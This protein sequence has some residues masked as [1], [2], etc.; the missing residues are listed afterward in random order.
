LAGKDLGIL[1]GSQYTKVGEEIVQSPFLKD[2]EF[3][4]DFGY[5]YTRPVYKNIF[6][7]VAIIDLA[8]PTSLEE[9]LKFKKDISLFKAVSVSR[10][11]YDLSDLK[12][13]LGVFSTDVVVSTGFGAAVGSVVP[14]VGTIVGGATGLLTGA[15][16]GTSDVLA[17]RIAL[18]QTGSEE[19]SSGVGV[20]AGVSAELLTAGPV[21]KV[22]SKTFAANLSIVG[23]P[24]SIVYEL[25]DDKLRVVKYSEFK[26]GTGF[27]TKK[28]DVVDDFVVSRVDLVKDLGLKKTDDLFRLAGKQ[29]KQ[30]TSDFTKGRYV[31]SDVY[32]GSK[33]IIGFGD[34]FLSTYAKKTTKF[35]KVLDQIDVAKFEGVQRIKMRTGKDFLEKI[36]ETIKPSVYDDSLESISGFGKVKQMEQKLLI[37]KGVKTFQFEGY[38]ISKTQADELAEA[39][40]KT[41]AP[42]SKTKK[43]SQ[44]KQL[45]SSKTKPITDIVEYKPLETFELPKGKSI[46]GKDVDDYSTFLSQTR[47]KGLS[48]SMVKQG[49]EIIESPVIK[50]KTETLGFEGVKGKGKIV[51]TKIKGLPD[52]YSLQIAARLDELPKTDPF[53][54]IIRKTS[55]QEDVLGLGVTKIKAGPERKLL[56]ESLEQAKKPLLVKEF[57]SNVAEYLATGKE[58]ALKRITELSKQFDLMQ[59]TSTS[60]AAR[61]SASAK[62]NIAQQK[63]FEEFSKKGIKV[64]ETKLTSFKSDLQKLGKESQAKFLEFQ[65]KGPK[66]DVESQDKLSAFEKK[67]GG[68]GVTTTKETS[69]TLDDKKINDFLNKIEKPV[70]EKTKLK[71]L[72]IK[73][74][75]SSKTKFK[76]TELFKPTTQKSRGATT[77]LLE[78]VKTKTATKSL[79]KYESKLDSKFDN[80]YKQKTK[81]DTKTISDY[82][83]KTKTD[84]KTSQKTK[85][86]FSRAELDYKSNISKVMT[87][88]KLGFKTMTLSKTD[89]SQKQALDSL[90]K[91]ESLTD[92]KSLTDTVTR[93]DTLTDSITLT[94]TL[95]DTLTRTD[96]RLAEVSLTKTRSDVV[97]PTKPIVFP[98]PIIPRLFPSVSTGSD[99][100]NNVVPKGFKQGYDSFVREKRF[101]VMQETQVSNNK[102]FYKATKQA[103]KEADEFTQRTVVIKKSGFTKEKDLKSVGSIQKKFKKPALKSKLNKRGRLTLVEKSANAIDS[104]GEKLGIPY[105]SAKLKRD[106]NLS[107]LLRVKRI[108][109][110]L[111]F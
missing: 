95:S 49:D 17:K 86:L 109:S 41:Q 76:E 98:T 47:Q 38:G 22:V 77:V 55:K 48:K 64:D 50:F 99:K 94:D 6:E 52:E 92:T 27:L 10:E 83:Q 93:T 7:D 53:A 58:S 88:K 24:Q 106:S 23:K 57:E 68:R 82:K 30:L 4:K 69:I 59:K 28:F 84:T 89:V 60:A 105:K 11:P 66:L 79:S 44:A 74:I 26:S 75:D 40:T 71:T 2:S 31:I 1:L 13:D 43:I 35:D 102:P 46:F 37:K 70:L 100:T 85:D 16:G 25:A 42:I 73:K 19:F 108:K 54:D 33:E 18:A 97:S 5:K 72:D 81:T 78:K 56:T 107:N 34:D 3:G 9:E 14:G 96:T 104:R 29:T 80:A 101:G 39:I 65:S 15:V 91:T 90:T 51:T 12:E 62:T 63:F 8:A 45:T 20:V 61:F 111:K 36:G 32:K 110:T 103:M 87:S 21:S 67:Y